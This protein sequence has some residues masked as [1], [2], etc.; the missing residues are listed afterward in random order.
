MPVLWAALRRPVCGLA[1]QQ[2]SA[3]SAD[4]P[5]RQS[6]CSGGRGLLGAPWRRRR[7]Q[8]RQVG[9][10]VCSPGLGDGWC[11]G[12]RRD[13]CS[14]SSLARHCQCF[15]L[16]QHMPAHATVWWRGV[17]AWARRLAS[18][19]A[20][21]ARA[22]C[23]PHPRHPEG[24]GQRG[25]ARRGA[26]V[27]YPLRGHWH[28]A[29]RGS[30]AGAARALPRPSLWA[31]T[32]PAASIATPPRVLAVLSAVLRK[33]CWCRVRKFCMQGLRVLWRSDAFWRHGT[34][35]MH[36]LP[37]QGTYLGFVLWHIYLQR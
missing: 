27:P 23:T 25:C 4:I 1:R 5:N 3:R 10:L 35:T 19:L 13:L 6:C 16:R 33:P 15:L 34:G 26:D 37:P 28:V 11:R 17:F 36:T 14:K 2:Q 8:A 32:A 12:F 29:R 22:G 21:G 7:R 20:C 18:V 31:F 30:Q 24:A 9:A